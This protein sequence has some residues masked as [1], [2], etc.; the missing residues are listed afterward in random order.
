MIIVVKAWPYKIKAA[1]YK[2]M[3][4]NLILAIAG[5]ILSIY[6]M[7]NDQLPSRA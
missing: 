5:T 7:V 6:S 2:E 1:N 4:S 3:L